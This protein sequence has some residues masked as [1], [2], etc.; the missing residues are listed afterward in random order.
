M[1]SN[2]ANTLLDIT[3]SPNTRNNPST[4]VEICKYIGYRLGSKKVFTAHEVSLRDCPAPIVRLL[5]YRH[6]RH[7]RQGLTRGQRSGIRTPNAQPFQH[8]HSFR[9]NSR[10]VETWPPFT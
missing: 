3:R 8:A 1:K 7:V 2:S 9:F 4:K 5:L 10:N 6:D